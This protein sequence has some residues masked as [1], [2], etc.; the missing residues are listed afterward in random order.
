[1]IRNIIFDVGNVL[2]TYSP[3]RFLENRGYS[4]REREILRKAVFQS[5][6][7]LLSDRGVL[8]AGELVARF[9]ANA[10]EYEELIREAYRH[11]E[12]T[13]WEFPYAENWVKDLKER[14]YHTY[15]LSNYGRDLL[16]RT[17]EKMPFLPY[18][19]GAVFS[20]DCHMLKPEPEIYQYLCSR[21]GLLPA[22]SVFLDDRMEN[23][24]A[25][26]A[27][28]IQSIL[29]ESYEQA[30]GQLETLLGFNEEEGRMAYCCE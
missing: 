9:V 16:A 23:V 22:E 19:D 29:F 13:V 27:Y 18:M 10:P 15:V 14:G 2:V 3:E 30:A 6:E 24:R 4:E 12:E 20:C 28:G 5:P 25:A 1:M 7:W 11:A 8:D 26:R 21:Y 17:R